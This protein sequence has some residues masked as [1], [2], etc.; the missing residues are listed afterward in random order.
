MNA[1]IQKP[2]TEKQSAEHE[3]GPVLFKVGDR[4]VVDSDHFNILLEYRVD[5][6]IES[7]SSYLLQPINRIEASDNERFLEVPFDVVKAAP[8]TEAHGGF[9][10][11]IMDLIRRPHHAEA[12]KPNVYIPEIK[13]PFDP[14]VDAKMNARTDEIVAEEHHS[15]ESIQHSPEIEAVMPKIDEE[16]GKEAIKADYFESDE[17]ELPYVRMVGNDKAV[18]NKISVIDTTPA[19]EVL[20]THSPTEEKAE[21]VADEAEAVEQILESEVEQLEASF[22]EKNRAE[23]AIEVAREKLAARP[24]MHETLKGIYEHIIHDANDLKV[25]ATFEDKDAF[26]AEAARLEQKLD[27]TALEFKL[28]NINDIEL[29]EDTAGET[30]KDVSEHEDEATERKNEKLLPFTRGLVGILGA[31]KREN[32]RAYVELSDFSLQLQTVIKSSYDNEIDREAILDIVHKLEA[33]YD[34]NEASNVSLISKLQEA[35]EQALKALEQA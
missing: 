20:K 15:P 10:R 32:A 28:F 13:K 30:R 18:V 29:L 17:E 3:H 14:R 2:I 35:T 9:R 22:A 6:V 31:V 27:T 7:E 33:T 11:S 23:H 21:E 24:K 4:V 19:V 16:M 26:R 1:E 34:P 8:A 25:L 5:E 12:T